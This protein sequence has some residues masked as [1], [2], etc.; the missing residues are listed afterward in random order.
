[1]TFNQCIHI[2]LSD[3]QKY[4][5]IYSFAA[6]ILFSV[7]TTETKFTKVLD[8]VLEVGP[9]AQSEAVRHV[10]ECAALCDRR[11]TCRSANY[12]VTGA[13]KQCEIRDYVTGSGLYTA[14]TNG[15]MLIRDDGGES[16]HI[17]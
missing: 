17:D 9:S 2:K 11:A 3:H 10:L 1:M 14:N 16:T 4:I 13:L 8:N 7:V 15:L 12:I 5:F 6:C